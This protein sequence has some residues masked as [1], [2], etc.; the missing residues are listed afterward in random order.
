MTFS[1]KIEI[2]SL[3]VDL[4]QGYQKEKVWREF[5]KSTEMKFFVVETLSFLRQ[6]NFITVDFAGRFSATKQMSSL[7]EPNSDETISSLK[8][9]SDYPSSILATEL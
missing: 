4:K 2:S 5:N 3:F 9:Q 8:N 7:K 1:D 6:N